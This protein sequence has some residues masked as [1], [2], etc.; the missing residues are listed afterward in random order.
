MGVPELI[1]HKRVDGTVAPQVRMTDHGFATM[2]RDLLRREK[3]ATR[4]VNEVPFPRQGLVHEV[5]Q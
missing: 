1:L 5:A 2:L 4:M 3:S